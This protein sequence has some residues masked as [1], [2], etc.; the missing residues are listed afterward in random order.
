MNQLS[1]VR[2]STAITPLSGADAAAVSNIANALE[3]RNLEFVI[4]A[5]RAPSLERRSWMERRV[6][7]INSYLTPA[8]DEQIATEVRRLL[9]YLLDKEKDVD[10]E[11]DR[12]I[13]YA[14]ILSKQPLASLRKCVVAYLRAE[15]GDGKWMPKPGELYKAVSTVDRQLIEERGRLMQILAAK[16][17]LAPTTTAQSRARI[18]EDERRKFNEAMIEK[19]E[20]MTE[21][22]RQ[23]YKADVKAA[24]KDRETEMR[25]AEEWLAS[26]ALN[27]GAAPKLSTEALATFGIKQKQEAVG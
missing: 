21:R 5:A 8:T 23:D 6:A 3:R 26:A 12:L 19:M 1:T 18:I 14:A 24:P 25:E 17:L 11:K 16:V 20:F 15:R 22:Q 9:D 27:R 2:Q 10:G 7:E 4:P 13:T